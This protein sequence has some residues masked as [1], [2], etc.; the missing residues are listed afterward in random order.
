MNKKNKATITI[1][2]INPIFIRKMKKAIKYLPKDINIKFDKFEKTNKNVIVSASNQDFIMGGGIDALIATEYKEEC[3]KV[4]KGENQRIGNVI[5]TITVD[6]DLKASIKLVEES[7][8]FAFENIKKGENMMLT[9]LGTGIGELDIENFIWI[10]LKYVLEYYGYGFGIKYIRKNYTDFYS[11]KKKYIVG[12]KLKQI[13]TTF[14]GED[15]GIGLHVGKSFV[16]A[17]NYDCPER[18]LVC[19]FNKKDIAGS[20][21]DKIRV[22]KLLPIYELPVWCGYINKDYYKRLKNHKSPINTTVLPAKKVIQ[23]H[24]W[25]QNWTQVRNQVETQVG[26]QVWAQGMYQVETQVGN[27]V[28]TQVKAQVWDQVETQ[29]GNRVW[30]QVETQVGN[31]VW[32]QVRNQVWDQV[33]AIYNIL[34]ASMFDIPVHH[35]YTDF[36]KLGIIVIFIDDKM[37]VFGKK[38]KYLGEYKV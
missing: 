23:K 13:G 26:N 8:K 20:G 37:K 36:L 25:D 28:W 38:G 1:I 29:V 2:D 15:C 5:F 31:Q 32:A 19:M 24:L 16:G 4:T 18:I 11:G 6:K 3:K 27:Q 21:G 12:T 14:D 22:S 33:W 17:G 34:L 30:D 10:F 9:G 7:L 35:W